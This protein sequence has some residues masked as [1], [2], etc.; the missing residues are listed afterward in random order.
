MDTNAH[1]MVLQIEEVD[2]AQVALAGGKGAQL[3]ALTRLRGVNVPPGFC[4][5][6][7]VYREAVAAD[8]AVTELAGRLAA[9]NLTDPTVAIGQLGAELRAAVAAVEIPPGAASEIRAEIQRLGS[10]GA[11]AVRSSSTAEDAAGAS[12]AGQHETFLGVVGAD[13]V[14]DHVR[15]CWASL[16][17]E[18]AITYRARTGISQLG[19][20]MAVVVQ[21]MVAAEAA[22]VMFTADPISGNRTVTSVEAVRGL[23]EG[24]VAGVVTPDRYRVKDG[25]VETEPAGSGDPVLTAAEAVELAELGRH[26]E[27]AFGSPQDIEWCLADGEFSV[28]Q[29]RPVTALFPVPDAG[30]GGRHVFVSVGHQQ[31]MTDPM[32]PLGLS[33]WQ[34]TALP[35]MHE[36]G[37]RLFVDVAE[38][39]AVPAARDAVVAMLGKGD[40]LIGDAMRTIVEREFIPEQPPAGDSAPPPPRDLPHAAP[41]PPDPSIVDELVAETQ[42]SLAQLQ[43]DIAG[44]TGPA[45]FEFIL[46]DIQTLKQI[47][48]D[49]RSMPAIMA[50]MDAAWW[51]NERLEAWLGEKN[52]ADVLVQSVPGNVTSEMGLALLDV[53]DAVRPHDA[54][55]ALLESGPG[56]EFLDALPGLA[57]GAEAHA[58]I[59]GFLDRY[60]MRC[61]GEIDITRPRWR[62]HPSALIPA[63]LS[64]VRGFEPGAGPRRF[65]EGRREA[66]AKASDVLARLRAL[67]GG[68]AKAEETAA[69]IDRLR[70][71][72]GYREF[73]KFGIVCRYFTYKQAL[74]AEAE[75]LAASGA[76]E[77][78]EDCFFL[79]FD[80]FH[81]ASRGEPVDAR[82]I[83]ERAAAFTTYAALVPPRVITSEGESINGSYRREDLP[84][85]AIPGLPVSAGT[86]EGRARVVHDL[87]D[88]VF[89]P[90]DI[91]VTAF[92]DPSWT[93]AFVAISGLVAEVGGLMT[94][95]AVIAREYGLPAVVGVDRAT[96]LVRDGQRIR[97]HGT[98]GFVELL[99]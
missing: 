16:F 24:L 7:A 62:E 27:A 58:A 78:P 34:L 50:G 11:Y 84:V 86:V 22:G 97:V 71:F 67:P 17:T 8:P 88:A 21:R 69:V 76:L 91:L 6:T 66:E 26:I 33:L 98:S 74:M 92:T 1:A 81:A 13:A 95:G 19:A 79:Q 99:D 36:A 77:C 38:R 49:P 94:H 70:A 25:Q 73:P 63:I 93:P 32:K 51:L 53:A 42:A 37:G 35:R 44:R 87:A 10:G 55:V 28:V 90:G 83:A 52:A 68:A 65:E 82:L 57:G 56:D 72:S 89:E 39:L 46:D 45:L 54:V 64:N 41:V 61:V 14:L 75:R 9:R 43:R 23:G 3:G 60:G 29:S 80:E 20:E 5:T 18:Q 47:T 12:F 59:T 2:G 31:M 85:G 40:P 48:F 30:D 4:V 15:R 96:Q